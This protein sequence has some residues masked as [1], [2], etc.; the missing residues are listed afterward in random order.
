MR[1]TIKMIRYIRIL[2]KQ[3]KLW[4]FWCAVGC[5][6]WLQMGC[7]PDLEERDKAQ[8]SFGLLGGTIAKEHQAVGAL[9]IH[10]QQAFC[11]GTLVEARTILTAAHCV[12]EVKRLMNAGT[13]VEWRVGGL[14][15]EER[16][17]S[18][19]RVASAVNYPTWSAE[20]GEIP[21]DDI[22]LLFLERVVRHVSPLLLS[23][24]S[25]DGVAL[26][27][28]T[29]WVGYGWLQTEPFPVHALQRYEVSLPMIQRSLDR[30]EGYAIGRSAC[31][32]D[33]G[34]GV[35]LKESDGWRVV[36]VSSYGMGSKNESG[37]ARCDGTSVAF[38]VDAYRAWITK[39]IVQSL[40]PCKQ[41]ADC[42]GGARC[43]QGRCVLVM[44][45]A[46]ASLCRPCSVSQQ[47]GAG[48]NVCM[49]M[50]AERRCLQACGKADECPTGYACGVL[51][52][53]RQCLPNSGVCRDEVCKKDADCGAV[54]RCEQG[55]CVA[56]SLSV[57]VGVCGA[58]KDGSCQAGQRCVRLEKEISRCLQ[59]C[60]SDAYCPTGYR[61][62]D[63][64]GGR[65]CVPNDG[66]CGC[67][68][69]RDCPSVQVCRAGRC[70]RAK[71]RALDQP[72]DEQKPCA[73]GLRCAYN[74]A[75]QRIC[76]RLCGLPAKKELE[77]TLGTP[78]SFCRDGACGAGGFCAEVA[79]YAAPI[80]FAQTCGSDQDC[81]QGGRCIDIKGV[82]KSCI[83]DQDK[84]C[85][86]GHC[87]KGLFRN[88]FRKEVGACAPLPPVL[89]EVDCL[90]GTLCKDASKDLDCHVNSVAC[91]CRRPREVGES[92]GGLNSCAQGL[93]CATT[94]RG[95]LCLEPCVSGAVGGCTQTGGACVIAGERAGEGYC[96][97]STLHGCPQELHCQGG[98]AGGL[99]YCAK[100]DE[101][102]RCGD[103]VCSYGEDC[104]NCSIDCGCQAGAL[105]YQGVCQEGG[106]T[107]WLETS[108]T[109]QQLP[110][111]PKTAVCPPSQTN[112]I[113]GNCTTDTQRVSCQ[114]FDTSLGGWGGWGWFG[115]LG[116]LV[117]ILR[118]K[119]MIRNPPTV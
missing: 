109:M 11:S 63:I 12:D 116:C 64:A 43:E 48:G 79:G 105:C 22:G 101:G 108:K 33:S 20:D 114:A 117:L 54:E 56:P 59:D 84:D 87:E 50:G 13:S 119:R 45:A 86:T 118:R 94:D 15:G 46:H 61:C 34:G 19:Y 44:A 73:P 2:M 103:G 40:P 7:L 18:F 97:C 70:E 89:G 113:G 83:C 16:V 41:D 8:S 91:V 67:Q 95:S 107:S 100:A 96:G 66:M 80:C 37:Q 115:W 9:V 98:L 69:D 104:E 5:G 26:G 3:R 4:F 85:K 102:P 75:N 27:A 77:R 36:G 93:R 71:G 1:R 62:Q 60:V 30:F 52:S 72:C 10:R 111:D 14:V 55:R 28:E 106:M 74:Q 24:R 90:A 35:L 57:G 29:I 76:Q 88:V 6:I 38:R 32:G 21:Q 51:Y 25:L 82:G 58:C 110:C 112:C 47:C 23:S 53:I 31:H 92:C 42:G 81:S 39:T 68:S 78:G 99:G 49:R 65:S 17:E